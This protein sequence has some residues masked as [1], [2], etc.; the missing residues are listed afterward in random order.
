L[1]RGVPIIDN[2]FMASAK[3][4]RLV[5]RLESLWTP[6]QVNGEN[7]AINGHRTGIGIFEHASFDTVLLNH[8]FIYAE[9][10]FPE[11]IVL[12]DSHNLGSWTDPRLR[13]QPICA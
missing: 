4:G 11:S 6:E 10:S 2:T 1:H 3:G 7:H 8:R 5:S 13:R 9:Q 12:H